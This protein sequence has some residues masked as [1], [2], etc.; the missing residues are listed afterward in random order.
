MDWTNIVKMSRLFK[1]IYTLNA[2][3]IKIHIHIHG[4][5]FSHKKEGNLAMCNNVDRPRGHYAK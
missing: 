5:L 1:V 3:P 2:I 4:I